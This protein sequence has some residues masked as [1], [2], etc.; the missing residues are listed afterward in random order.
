[1]PRYCLFRMMETWCIDGIG[2]L[3]F[4]ACT[5]LL[6]PLPECR[7]KATNCI[8]VGCCISSTERFG[9]RVPGCYTHPAVPQHP[10]IS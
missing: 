6:F 1:M 10:N 4:S 3:A 7:L 8:R 5:C 9:T 2:L